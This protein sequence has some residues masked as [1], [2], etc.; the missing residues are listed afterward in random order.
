MEVT[1]VDGDD[2]SYL[3]SLPIEVRELTMLELDVKDILSYCQ[4][5]KELNRSCKNDFFWQRKFF[6]DFPYMP[7]DYIPEGTWRQAYK[8]FST[9]LLKRVR[10]GVG[11]ESEHMDYSESTTLKLNE[12]LDLDEEGFNLVYEGKLEWISGAPEENA[13]LFGYV[14]IASDGDKIYDLLKPDLEREQLKDFYFMMEDLPVGYVREEE[15]EWDG[16]NVFEL[17]VPIRPILFRFVKTAPGEG[18]IEWQDSSGSENWIIEFHNP[19]HDFSGLPPEM[20]FLQKE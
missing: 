18:F 7:L 2:V 6:W 16:T 8:D 1:D 14:F 5:S 19:G 17:D 20:E 9:K 11:T 12:L 10:I 13:D 3:L 15:I 4:A